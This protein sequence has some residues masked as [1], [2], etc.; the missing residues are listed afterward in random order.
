MTKKTFFQIMPIA[1][2]VAIV[3]YFVTVSVVMAGGGNRGG[4]GGNRASSAPPSR[5]YSQARDRSQAQADAANRACGCDRNQP[6]PSRN[7]T[8]GFN[9]GTRTAGS[10]NDNDRNR[11]GT[12]ILSR[13]SIAAVGNFTSTNVASCSVSGWA[14]DGDNTAT[15]IAVHIYQD[16]WAGTPGAT[17]LTSCQANLAQPAPPSR[18]YFDDDDRRRTVRVPGR[19]GFNCQLPSSYFGTGN[20]A[21]YI[22]AI[23]INGA[24]NNLIAGSG[25]QLNCNQPV[26]VDPSQTP[27]TLTASSCLISANQSTCGSNMSWNIQNAGA[28]NIYNDTTDTQY[29]TQAVQTNV[30]QAITYGDNRIEARNG[31]T[32][33]RTVT[34]TA[35]CATPAVWNGSVCFDPA[36]APPIT[37]ELEATTNIVRSGARGEVEWRI[38]NLTGQVCRLQGPGVNA[39][40]TTTTGTLATE[41]ITNESLY[42][43]TCTGTSA[44][45][46]TDT[47]TIEVVAKVQEV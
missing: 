41:P 12:G 9:A 35:A 33:L 43:L 29:S 16:G 36:V 26:V 40:I 28:P 19:H 5:S 25:R 32:V 13:N 37:V 3:V 18:T 24:P 10:G 21:L 15:S 1:I 30:T 17:F 23:D 39:I 2:L 6:S 46:V 27:A 38:S 4:G 31:A 22:H 47:A 8:G 14:Y 45:S 44:P 20:H 34:A 42:T 7:A 11:T